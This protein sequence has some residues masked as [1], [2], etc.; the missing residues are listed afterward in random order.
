MA[1]SALVLTLSEDAAERARALSVL[2]ATPTITLGDLADLRLPIVTE[3]PTA[4]DGAA[5][6][7]WLLEVPGVHLVDL[8]FADFSNEER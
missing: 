1:V 2:R 3:T 7:E 6:A 4:R 5:L 8:V